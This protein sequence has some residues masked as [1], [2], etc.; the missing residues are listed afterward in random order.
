MGLSNITISD[1]KYPVALACLFLLA[2]KMRL[3]A[4]GDSLTSSTTS[5]A[6]LSLAKPRKH[7]VLIVGCAYGGVTAVVNLLA[8][9]K[10]QARQPVY[11]GA[12]FGGKRSTR[13]I[14]ITVIDPR[15]GYCKTL[16]ITLCYT[17]H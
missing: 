11:P 4:L 15:D 3:P 14:E 16:L 10:G 13:G 12:E 17:I 1:L 5:L 7:R 6:K 2:S 8:L 9:E